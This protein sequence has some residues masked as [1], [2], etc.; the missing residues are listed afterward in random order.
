MRFNVLCLLLSILL[1]SCLTVEQVIDTPYEL[2]TETRSI[3]GYGLSKSMSQTDRMKGEMSARQMMTYQV[4][5][6]D[7]SWVKK[8]NGLNLSVS[9]TVQ[10]SQITNREPVAQGLL[11][12]AFVE[13]DIQYLSGPRISINDVSIEIDSVD[14]AVKNLCRSAVTA[15]IE[16]EYPKFKEIAG[17]LSILDMTITV[18]EEKQMIATATVHTVVLSGT[19]PK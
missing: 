14:D 3:Y 6:A 15:L 5:P 4:V 7:F 2:T 8:G 1:L 11:N 13:T 19:G 10:G 9:A 17:K 16:S 18:N 12:T